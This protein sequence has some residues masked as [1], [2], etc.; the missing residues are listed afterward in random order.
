MS[1]WAFHSSQTPCQ[2]RPARSA[3]KQHWSSW[4]PTSTVSRGSR[5]SSYPPYRTLNR[6]TDQIHCAVC[7]ETATLTSNITR[8]EQNKIR[9]LY[10]HDVSVYFNSHFNQTLLQ[11]Q[12]PDRIHDRIT[13]KVELVIMT[14]YLVLSTC[15]PTILICNFFSHN[16]NVLSQLPTFYLLIFIFLI[17]NSDFSSHY[18]DFWLVIL[19]YCFI[20]RTYHGNIVFI[21][22]LFSSCFFF[23][24]KKWS[25]VKHTGLPK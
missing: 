8:L 21:N 7:L 16:F 5:P 9:H 12:R 15:Y 24:W 3:W 18:P 4:R 25:S 23:N 20:I 19:I 2:R 14:F 10:S 6:T 17:H 22:A 11:T 13:I 1:T